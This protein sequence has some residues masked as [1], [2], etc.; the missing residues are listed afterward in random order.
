MRF[1]L[2]L[3]FT[4]NALFS[5]SF[6]YPDFKKCYKK[7]VKSIVYF[8]STQAIAVSKHYAVAYLKK[9][10]KH[11]FVRYDPFLNL[12]LFYSKKNLHPV[13]LKNTDKLTLGEWLASMDDDS[14]YTGNFAQ[15]GIGLNI[16]FKQNSKTPPN[17]MISCLCCSIYG[18]GVGNGK[19]ISSN[20]I[21]RFLDSKSV[22][23]GDIGVRFLRRGKDVIVSSVNPMF[24]HQLLE[25]GDIIKK[26]DSKKV[27]KIEDI[28][29]YILFQKIGKI[30]K[31]QF[32][33]NN[34]L[35]TQKIKVLKRYGGGELSDS[36]LERKGMFFDKNLRIKA[37]KKGSFAWKS[38]LRTGDKLLQIDRIN[39]ANEDDIRR[40]FSSLKKKEVN[41]LFDRNDFQFFIKVVL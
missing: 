1:I 20:F 33:R 9:K 14:M 16:F 19:F 15:R 30:V 5:V 8:G 7:D 39:V 26:I 17:S 29:D 36:F 31:L 32:V 11:S 4:V 28:E 21:K 10:P 38:G 27:K 12:Y 41:L 2:I 13:K 40:I 22:A 3:I 25:V 34:K 37:I 35:I 18:I 6:T 23:Y 24:P